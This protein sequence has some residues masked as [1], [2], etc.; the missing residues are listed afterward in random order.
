V[1]Q[2]NRAQLKVCKALGPGSADLSGHVFNFDVDLQGAGM[3][4]A[5]GYSTYVSVVASAS[6][7]QCVVA[8]DFPVGADV[9]V[10]EVFGKTLLGQSTD[11]GSFIDVS[12]EG[13]VHINPGINS[14]TITNTARGLLEVCKAKITYLTGTQPTFTF[15]IDGAKTITVQAGKCSPPM[16]VSVGQHTVNERLTQPNFELD[17][18][19]PGGGITA[20]PAAA[21][22]SKSI[23]GRTITVHVSYGQDT[24]VTFYNRVRRGQVKICKLVPIGSQDAIGTTLFSFDEVINPHSTNP[25][26]KTDVTDLMNGECDIVDDLPILQPNGQ[27][28]EVQIQEETPPAGVFVTNITFTGPGTL[29]QFSLCGRSAN[30]FLGAGINISTFSNQEGVAPPC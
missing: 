21:E 2:R 30:I 28:T 29:D 24:A 7:T 8:G 17:P 15:V 3:I 9:D 11:D 19:A 10:H 5:Y 18:W 23:P 20:T 13:T 4:P 6:T 27:A 16:R 12:G 14:I 26:I 22:V 1:N 25:I